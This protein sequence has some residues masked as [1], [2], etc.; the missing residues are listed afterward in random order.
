MKHPSNTKWITT[1]LLLVALACGGTDATSQ[2]KSYNVVMRAISDEGQPVEGAR[3]VQGDLAFGT[4]DAAGTVTSKI[5]GAD[6]QILAVITTCPD[7]YLAP[8]APAQLRL[9]EVR[10]LDS[11]EPAPIELEVVCTRKMRDIVLVV[12]TSQA[13]VLPVDVSGRTVGNTDALGQAHYQF[14]LDRSVGRM[15]V[16]LDTSQAP[17]LRPQNPSRVFELDG[18]DAVLLFEQTFTAER[19]APQPRQV[20]VAKKKQ[21]EQPARPIPYRIDSGRSHVF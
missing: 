7:G 14:Q 5:H 9:A 20:V 6:G 17:K 10:R 21:V 13:P 3:F 15:S 2:G 8:E 4:S 16:S 19:Q 18:Q 12:R 11:A 1:P